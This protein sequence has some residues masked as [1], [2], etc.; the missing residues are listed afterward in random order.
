MTER[1]LALVVVLALSLFPVG[2][3]GLMAVLGISWSLVASLSFAAEGPDDRP[4]P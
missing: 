4:G 2:P 1:R 3:T